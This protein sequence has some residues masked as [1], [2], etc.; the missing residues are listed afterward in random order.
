MFFILYEIASL[1]NT[2]FD[3]LHEWHRVANLSNAKINRFFRIPVNTWRWL[4]FSWQ[5]FNWSNRI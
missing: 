3:R 1:P 2:I 5:W 4:E